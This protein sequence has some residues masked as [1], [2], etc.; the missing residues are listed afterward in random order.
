MYTARRPQRL[1]PPL[2]AVLLL[3]F[4]SIAAAENSGREWTLAA[5]IVAVVLSTVLAVAGAR[6]SLVL[7][8]AVRDTQVEYRAE[9]VHLLT[10]AEKISKK[11]VAGLG[12][13]VSRALQILR[14]QQG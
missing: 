6:A 9:V 14:E 11:P 1:L 12:E 7:L 5:A 2:A 3:V 4:A 13:R 8:T 10:E